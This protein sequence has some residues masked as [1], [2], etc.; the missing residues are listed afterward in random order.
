MIPSLVEAMLPVII[1]FKVLVIGVDCD[2]R[3]LAE[4]DV[5]KIFGLVR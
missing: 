1:Y 5:P 4:Y 3:T 2:R